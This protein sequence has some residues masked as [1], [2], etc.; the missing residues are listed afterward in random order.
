MS[1][2]RGC[3]WTICH[4]CALARNEPELIHF[5]VMHHVL[6]DSWWCG[7]CDELCRAD[8]SNLTFRCDR[9]HVVRDSCGRRRRW[10]CRFYR[11]MFTGTWFERSRLSVS[12]VCSL[13]FFWLNLN[14]PRQFKLIKEVG[15][16]SATVVE[17]SSF[18]REVCIFL[19]WQQSVVLGGPGIVV[20]I[21]E[22]KFG[23][24]KYNRGRWLDG[25]RVF[26]GLEHGSKNC[27]L[28]C[29]PSCRSD[30]LLDV[31]KQWIRPGTTVVSDCWKAY[32]CLSSEGFVH[33]SVNHSKNFVDPKLRAHT[34]KIER[35]WREVRG[36]FPRFG[37][38]KPHMVGNLAEFMFKCKYSDYRDRAHAFFT[39]AGQ[40]YSPAPQQ[41]R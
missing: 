40:L 41:S 7:S 2:C 12:K 35:T 33:E 38:K 15:V 32:D 27:F 9:R 18:C 23:K 21:Y 30:V 20:E 19:V 8:F 10:R 36:G 26:G 1:S 28:V 5:L 6:V 39:A 13:A 14:Y 16:S 11:S 24:Q 29:M 4:F 34:Q 17:W 22:A 25:Q 3:K 31:I 37:R